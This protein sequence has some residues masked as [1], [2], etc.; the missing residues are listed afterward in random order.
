VVLRDGVILRLDG[1]TWL[2]CAT[3]KRGRTSAVAVY[4]SENLL[5]WRLVR[6]ALRTTLAAPKQPPWAA[7]ESPFVFRRGDESRFRLAA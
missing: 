3:G 4:V 1:D 5:D 2:H 7:T 6:F